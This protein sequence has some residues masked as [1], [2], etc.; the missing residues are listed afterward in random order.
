MTEEK[1][2]ESEGLTAEEYEMITAGLG[3]Q[4]NRTE[5]GMFGVMWSEHCS[6]KNSLAVLRSL[7][8]EGERVL[9]GPGENAGII[10]IGDGQAVSFKI[11]SHNHPS[12]IEPYQGAA[13]GVGGIIRDIFTMGARPIALLDSLRF[14]ELD[15][16][17]VRYLFEEVVAGIAGYGNSIGVPTV[18]G[19]TFFSPSYRGNPL[20]NAMC[21]G[22][23]DQQDISTATARGIG[24]PVMVVGAA[25]GRD[26]IQGASF[27]SDELTEESEEDRPAVQVGDPFREKLL[28]EASLEL[29]K[30]G[31]LVG[32]QDM[33][34]AGL[35]SSSSEMA[36][37]G[38]AGIEMD[39]ALVPKR[40]E[41]MTPYEV[42]LSESQERML[43][44]PRQGKEE[45][46]KE[47][48]KKWGLK[49]AVIGKVTDDGKIRVY[50]QGEPAAEVPVRLLVDDAPV[51]QREGRRPAY[52]NELQEFSTGD[53]LAKQKKNRRGTDYNQE[54]V[55]LLT[56]ENLAAKNSIYE[57]YDHMV[58]LNTVILPGS[59]AAVL[60]IK[61]KNKGLALTV[62]CN[63]RYCYL[64]PERGAEIAVAEAARNLVCSGAEPL[65]VT[66]G[67]NFGNPMNP[68]VFW[69]FERAAAGIAR[70]CQEL[71]TPVTGGNV[72]F[73]NESPAG[74]IYPTP[75]IGMV[76]LLEDLSQATDQYFKEEG[77]LIV[78]LGETGAELG[79]SE[80]LKVIHDRV[81]GKIP[82]L[83]YIR[84]KSVQNLCLKAIKQGL[85]KSAHDCAE[86]GLAVAL[87]ESCSGNSRGARVTVE[88]ELLPEELLFSESQ[89]RIIISLDEENMA[90]FS[91]LADKYQAGYQI[92][93]RV[94]GRTLKIN[95]LIEVEIEELKAKWQAALPA[96]IN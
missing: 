54:L 26:G 35:I 95:N 43:V 42:L 88:T 2:W 65:A 47:I 90:E 73:Y 71:A 39:T 12:A 38:E 13:T 15:D 36:S 84:E 4:P 52:L 57:Q 93:G 51:Y 75:I 14:G 11:E 64:D 66:D 92:I 50:N 32:I 85:I 49:A 22:L 68:E 6:Y 20:V 76:G 72:S 5:L 61:G 94:Q 17:H 33:G 70:A 34:A 87:F 37:R 58:Q 7:P 10:D 23:M 80:Y 67:L 1:V 45:L 77:D 21:V 24:N 82:E 9:Q 28:M 74:A 96:M 55:K 83:D 48:F 16:E 86:G 25:T 78:L 40:E 18:A 3:R 19:E 91:E 69:Q 41:G 60:R 62:D 29:I 56:S 30:T 63:G 81:G 27:A 79:G 31:A 89:S 46:V 44:V 8:T 59:D 53:F